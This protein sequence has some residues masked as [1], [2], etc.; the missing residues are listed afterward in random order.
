MESVLLQNNLRFQGLLPFGS[1]AKE[2]VQ[3]FLSDALK[4]PSEKVAQIEIEKCFRVGKPDPTKGSD[5]H[6]ILAVFLRKSDVTEILNAVTKKPKGIPGGVRPD[7]PAPWEKKHQEL[8][9]NYV[10]P[11]RLE[12]QN[13]KVKW[14]NGGLLIN[15]HQIDPAVPWK[16]TKLKLI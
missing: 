9:R 16:E 15:N 2:T 3:H 10:F 12:L 8:Y 4:F 1:S 11:A 14:Q 7:L 5:N 13:V 6:S